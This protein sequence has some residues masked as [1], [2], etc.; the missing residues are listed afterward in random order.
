MEKHIPVSPL[1]KHMHLSVSDRV[2]V[3]EVMTEST[4][5]GLR[6]L[7]TA[8]AVCDGARRFIHGDISPA[9]MVFDPASKRAFIKL[10]DFER[11]LS[12][13]TRGRSG[14]REVF[15]PGTDAPGTPVWRERASYS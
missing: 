8:L 15:T 14:K 2:K 13:P 1:L 9:N 7:Q 6:N 12:I 4:L 11:L 3:V 10:I 5:T